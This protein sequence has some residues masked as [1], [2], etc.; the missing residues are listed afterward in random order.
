M[1]TDLNVEIPEGLGFRAK[2]LESLEVSGFQWLFR[3]VEGVDPYA[4]A[5]YDR[6]KRKTKTILGVP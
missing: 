1:P 5:A 2:A 4:D 6:A 3:A